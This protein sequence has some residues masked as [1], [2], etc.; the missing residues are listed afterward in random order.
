MNI[1]T[2]PARLF[3][4]SDR[5]GV[6]NVFDCQPFNRRRQDNGDDS[7]SEQHQKMIDLH[8]HNKETIKELRKEV[9]KRKDDINWSHEKGKHYRKEL[10]DD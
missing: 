4:D 8:E 5:D 3:R 9:R 6:A 2:R 10:E 1:E 7:Y